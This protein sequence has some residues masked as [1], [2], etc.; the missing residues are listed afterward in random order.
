MTFLLAAEDGGKSH[1]SHDRSDDR[2]GHG[3]IRMAE[4]KNF[5]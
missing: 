2:I 3:L 4:S 5:S 1:T